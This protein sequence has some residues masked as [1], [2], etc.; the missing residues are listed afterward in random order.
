M[1]LF[2]E[3]STGI[4]AALERAARTFGWSPSE[5]RAFCLTQNFNGGGAPVI[6]DATR[7]G[8]SDLEGESLEATD[9]DSD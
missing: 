6:Y 9:S 8:E 1:A 7:G 3:K 5:T 4:D 2:A